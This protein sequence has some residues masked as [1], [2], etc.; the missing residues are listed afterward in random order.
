MLG[1]MVIIYVPTFC[2]APAGDSEAGGVESKLRTP[3]IPPSAEATLVPGINVN[4]AHATEAVANSEDFAATTTQPGSSPSFAA[5][6]FARG[7]IQRAIALEVGLCEEAVELALESVAI[8]T[9]KTYNARWQRF[10]SWCSLQAISPLRPTP[11][12]VANFL[13]FLSEKGARYTTVRGFLSAVAHTLRLKPGLANLGTHPVVVSIFPALRRRDIKRRPDRRLGWDLGVVLAD[14]QSLINTTTPAQLTQTALFLLAFASG[15]RVSE[16]A[17]LRGPPF[18]TAEGM[19]LSFDPIF[20]PKRTRANRPHAPLPPLHVLRLPP[21]GEGPCPVEAMLRYVQ[22]HQNLFPAHRLWIHPTNSEV[23]VTPRHLAAWLRCVIAGAYRRAC[24]QPEGAIHPH[25]IR[26]AA[27]TWA[28]HA[29]IPLAT[30]L[31]QCRWRD[32]STFTSFYLRRLSET[33]G[34]SF[35]LKPLAVASLS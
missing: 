27:A 3:R 10:V 12:Q 2:F 30:I 29:N 32:E 16:L 15:A 23:R 20:I 13:T 17:A 21:G 14:L 33:D 19:T 5:A 7:S 11:A 22:Y 28:W 26:A 35:R 18:I 24:K 25:T 1:W 6:K 8:S 4:P 34:S 31:E 9:N